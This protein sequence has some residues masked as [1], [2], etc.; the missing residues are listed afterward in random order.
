LEHTDAVERGRVSASEPQIGR[1]TT[2]DFLVH[3]H[4][5]DL[6]LRLVIATVWLSLLAALFKEVVGTDTVAYLGS[7]NLTVVEPVILLQAATLLQLARR[8]VLRANLVTWLLLGIAAIIL[9]NLGRGVAHDLPSGLRSFRI[10]GAFALYLLIAALVPRD[11]AMLRQLRDA[12]ILTALLFCGLVAL[13]LTFGP[14]LFLRTVA[15]DAVTIND[16]GRPLTA[17]GALMLGIGLILAASRAIEQVRDR[18]N[19]AAT[20]A[21]PVLLVALVLSAQATAIIAS[22]A[23]LAVVTALHPS[24]TRGGRVLLVTALV[25]AAGIGVLAIHGAFGR[26]AP[27]ILPEYFQRN[28]LRRS[29]TF[30]FRRLIWAGLV[31][32]YARWSLFEQTFGLRN[33]DLPSIYIP[34]R[35]GYYWRWSIHSMYYGALAVM[36]AAGLTLYLALLGT[37]A[38]RGLRRAFGPRRSWTTFGGAIPLGLLTSICFFGYSYELRDEHAILILLALVASRPFPN[39]APPPTTF[40]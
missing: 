7:Y 39:P 16:G 28:L 23:G 12:L 22:L 35:T 24:A 30:E 20:L 11:D 18:F 29:A 38:V 1:P 5:V 8:R 36:G 25:L 4:V 32:D 40:R 27:D 3:R 34:L 2:L 37:I 17:D 33:N 14:Q 21:I 9:M 31:Q 13:R 15:G 6:D 10:Q 26:F 19:R